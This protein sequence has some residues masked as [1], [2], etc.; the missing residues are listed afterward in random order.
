MLDGQ[1]AP[2]SVDLMLH[3]RRLASRLRTFRTIQKSTWTSP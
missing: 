3:D 2:E 1:D